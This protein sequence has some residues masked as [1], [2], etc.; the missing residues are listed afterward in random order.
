MQATRRHADRHNSEILKEEETTE[1][2]VKVQS[3]FSRQTHRHRETNAVFSLAASMRLSF[4]LLGSHRETH[5]QSWD[6]KERSGRPAVGW[7]AEIGMRRRSDAK[8]M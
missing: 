2:G 5:I 3:I 6:A 8:E 4:H 7:Q 1:G